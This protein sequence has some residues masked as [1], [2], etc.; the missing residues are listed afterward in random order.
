MLGIRTTTIPVTE[1]E[2]SLLNLIA[3]QNRM[4][5]QG[6]PDALVLS[7]AGI[8]RAAVVLSALARTL[9]EHDLPELARGIPESYCGTVMG[10]VWRSSREYQ[11]ETWTYQ[12]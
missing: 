11:G 9:R 6:G 1:V 4:Q 12:G 2:A 5:H 8:H 7:P 3:H 10:E